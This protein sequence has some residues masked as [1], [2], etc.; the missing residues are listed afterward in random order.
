MEVRLLVGAVIVQRELVG[1]DSYL[2]ELR[3]A[4]LDTD[5]VQ[6]RHLVQQGDTADHEI[7]ELIRRRRAPRVVSA[8]GVR[9]VD[10][11]RCAPLG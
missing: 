7:R 3:V 9:C 10:L 4:S 6:M 1:F 11:L 2:L 8:L 5:D